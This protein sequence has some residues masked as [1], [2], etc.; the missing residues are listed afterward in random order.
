VRTKE[1]E[2]EYYSNPL[3]FLSSYSL[4]LPGHFNPLTRY[5]IGRLL[6]QNELPLVAVDT[7]LLRRQSIEQLF[8]DL[9]RLAVA[10]HFYSP[11]GRNQ[12]G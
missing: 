8:G 10:G 6:H 1:R 2:L 3:S 11:V 5:R 12:S 9:N 4:I 7:L